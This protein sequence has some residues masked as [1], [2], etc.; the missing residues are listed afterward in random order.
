M[1]SANL[2]TA[3]I[4]RLLVLLFVTFS[5][6]IVAAQDNS[7]YS[8]YGLGDIVPAQNIASRG[9][10]GISVAFI[11]SSGFLPYSQ[12]INLTNP[13]ALG[14]LNT[15][16]FDIGG[17]INIRT[18]KSNNSPTKSTATNTIFNYLQLG[19]PITPKKMLA[20][21]NTWNIAF[22]LKPVTRVNYKI[23]ADTRLVGIDSVS[24]L[25]EGTGGLNQA[26]FSTGIKIKNFSFG[27]TTGYSFGNKNTSTKRVFI[28]DTVSYQQSNTEASAR[29]NGFFL[30]VGAQYGIRLQNKNVLRLG[31]T[32]NLQQKLKGKADNFSET[33]VYDND[34]NVV[35]VDSVKSVLNQSGTVVVPAT[36]TGGFT[37]TTPH[38]IVG[39]EVSTSQWDNYSYFGAKDAV[40]NNTMFRAGAQYYPA[41]ITT[42]TSKYWSFVKYR[43]G[44][45]YGNDYV[46]IGTNRPNL[47][48]TFGAGLPL[49]SFQRL[50]FGDFVTLNTG[51]EIGQNGNKQNQSL[52]EG[53]FRLNFGVSMTAAWFQKRKY[54]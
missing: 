16:L 19:F 14:G 31:A 34:G 53:I 22:G 36:Y 49:T 41:T 9:M 12:S 50:R 5:Y 46:N 6:T 45:Y 42:P 26:N 48:V 54:E 7:P 28:N 37:Y 17:E 51:V 27:V 32:A 29:Y 20:K 15:T 18:L 10:G 24:T 47:G 21:G 44:F 8:R 11:D 38:W 25:F 4:K 33:F 40:Q 1:H 30:T 2:T 13:A 39:A 43:A 3:P 35:R 52:R 23:A